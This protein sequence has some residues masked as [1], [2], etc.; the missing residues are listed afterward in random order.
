MT[1]FFCYEI[2]YVFIS[3]CTMKMVADTIY[4]IVKEILHVTTCIC[5]IQY[6]TTQSNLDS[7]SLTSFCI[8]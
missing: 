2:H 4:S 8:L 7:A 3:T 6:Y 1:E 5:S